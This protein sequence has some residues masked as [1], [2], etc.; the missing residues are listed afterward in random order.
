MRMKELRDAFY[1]S[2][3][4][5]IELYTDKPFIGEVVK[6]FKKRGRAQH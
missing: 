6:L 2:G 1:G 4:A 3:C 5:F